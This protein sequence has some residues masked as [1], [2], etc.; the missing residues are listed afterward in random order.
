MVRGRY[1]SRT[2]RR[3]YKKLPGGKT[4]LFHLKRK[5]SKHQCGN[6][7]A[8][9]KGVLRERPYIMR[10]TAR[11]KKVPSRAFAGNLCSN[12]MRQTLKQR[13]RLM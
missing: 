7:G 11:T 1:K 2:F 9:L 3:V 4:K 5:P 12:C 10:N 13:A 6:C 8:V